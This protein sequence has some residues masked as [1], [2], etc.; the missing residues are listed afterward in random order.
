M[1]GGDPEQQAEGQPHWRRPSRSAIEQQRKRAND[2]CERLQGK[3]SLIHNAREVL[4]YVSILGSAASAGCALIISKDDYKTV[5]GLLGLGIAL[6]ATIAATLT[7][8]RAAD[9]FALS[10]AWRRQREDLDAMLEDVD[11]EGRM[12]TPWA[13]REFDPAA[14]ESRTPREG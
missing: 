10:N 3:G 7:P 6:L 14:E 11:D 1:E 2:M 4:V 12:P 13:A 9:A 8:Q 5:G